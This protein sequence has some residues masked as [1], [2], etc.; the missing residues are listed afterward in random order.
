MRRSDGSYLLYV[1]NPYAEYYND[2]HVQ[3]RYPIRKVTNITDF[4][5]LP[6]KYAIEE[7]LDYVARYEE[8]FPFSEKRVEF[9]NKVA[10]DGVAV[11]K[12]EL[13]GV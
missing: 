9:F 2:L 1:Y 8:D 5:I 7:K 3:S 12:I 4:P 11:F 13:D 10:P 6:A